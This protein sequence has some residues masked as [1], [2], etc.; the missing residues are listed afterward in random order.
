MNSDEGWM[1]RHD[2]GI[3]ETISMRTQLMA[4]EREKNMFPYEYIG[5]HVEEDVTHRYW[6]H[7]RSTPRFVAAVLA[8][9]AAT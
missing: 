7:S 8:V 9:R 6:A 2:S 4:T 3:L 1:P 5:S